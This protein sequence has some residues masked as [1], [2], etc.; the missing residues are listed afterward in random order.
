M[1]AF[2]F[3]FVYSNFTLLWSDNMAYTVSNWGN[4]LRSC[5]WLMYDRFLC[6]INFGKCAMDF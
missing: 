3:F 2:F 5:S 4:L 6:M 1:C